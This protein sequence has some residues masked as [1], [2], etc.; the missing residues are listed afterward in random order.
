MER[1]E[2]QMVAFRECEKEP[3]VLETCECCGEKLYHE[4]KAFKISGSFYCEECV[5]EVELDE[6][7][8][9]EEW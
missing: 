5:S 6:S 9:E 2:N 1:I 7:N 4:N 8:Y 3:R